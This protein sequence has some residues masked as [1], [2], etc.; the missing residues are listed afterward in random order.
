LDLENFGRVV[1][2]R[3]IGPGRGPRP[4]LNHRH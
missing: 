2:P 4:T 1:A 3:I